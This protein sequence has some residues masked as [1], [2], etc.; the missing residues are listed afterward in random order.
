MKNI[1][2]AFVFFTRLPL[3]KLKMFQLSAQYFENV[4]N[5]WAVVGW[6]TGGVMVGVLWLTSKF[7]SIGGAVILALLSR[8]LLTGALHED[9]LADFFDGFGG[10]TNK[11]RIL[12]IMKDSHIGT[13][14]VLALVI[15]FLLSFQVLQSFPLKML[16]ILLF[17]ADTFSKFLVANITL[18]LPYARTQATSKSGVVYQKMK[19][20]LFLVSLPFGVLPLLFLPSWEYLLALLFPIFLFLGLINLLKSKIQGYT[21]DTCGALFLLCE[22]SAWLGFLIIHINFQQL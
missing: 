13:Y 9:G 2:A 20:Q 7:L 10:G 1:F 8:L 19:W 17:V 12:E 15:Y 16:Y 21:G 18:F 6:L 22:L 5:Y 3:W 4:I 14:G 11:K